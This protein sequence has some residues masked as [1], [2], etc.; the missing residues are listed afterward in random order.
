[1]V[2]KFRQRA[3]NFNIVVSIAIDY[4]YKKLKKL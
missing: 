1:M 2:T 4:N 3:Q